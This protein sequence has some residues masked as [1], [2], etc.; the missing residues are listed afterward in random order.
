M[1]A[2]QH[3]P[4][5][6]PDS[7][8]TVDELSQPPELVTPNS[9]DGNRGDY[10]LLWPWANMSI[11]H[12]MMWK[13]TGSSLKSNVE[14]TWLVHDVLQ[15]LDFDIQDLSKFNASS[16]TSRFDAAQKEIPPDDV[17][18]I[19]RWKRVTIDISVPTR[20]KKKEGNSQTFSVDSLLYRPILDVIR[21]VFVE[22]S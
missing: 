20:E 13:A 10:S 22:A 9:L 7:F 14:V 2:Y 5:H 1:C 6:D 15:A 11:W 21:V 19:D 4:S 16:E 18:G 12:L 17:F 8:L 3:H